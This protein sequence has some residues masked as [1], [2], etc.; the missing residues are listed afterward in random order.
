MAK[1]PLTPEGVQKKQ[2]ELYNLSD[3]ELLK[4]STEISR[5]V[6]GWLLA[7]FDVSAEQEDYIKSMSEN[8]ALFQGCQFASGTIGRMPIRL[9][10]F[11][12]E[13]TQKRNSKK[14]SSVSAS[15]KAKQDPGGHTSF[16]G[17]VTYTLTF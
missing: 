2:E 3:E 16:E 12:K 17:S 5:D 13:V 14:K 6:R 4:I 7:N 15:V 9:E 8:F 1:L 10:G 11:E